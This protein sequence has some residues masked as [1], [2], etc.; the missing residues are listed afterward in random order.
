VSETSGR[1]AIVTQEVNESNT[2]MQRLMSWASAAA[3]CGSLSAALSWA[4]G[5]SLTAPDPKIFSPGVISGSASDGAPTFTSDGRTLYF[6][7]SGGTWGFILESH[8][9]G[10]WSSPQIAP[11]SGQWSDMQRDVIRRWEQS[12]LCLEATR[13]RL[14]TGEHRTQCWTLASNPRRERLE[15]PDPSS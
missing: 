7:R 2:Q 13:T 9:N 1:H 5:A 15:R 12:H 4:Q 11:F 6:T 14:N 10:D 8:F 3:I